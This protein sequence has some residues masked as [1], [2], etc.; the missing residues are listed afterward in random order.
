MYFQLNSG[1]MVR[2]LKSQILS[3]KIGEVYIEFDAYF[4]GS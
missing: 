4:F 1:A 3:I 2:K